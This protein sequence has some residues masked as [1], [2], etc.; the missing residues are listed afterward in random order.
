M[1][2]RK[3]VAFDP[4]IALGAMTF[5]GRTSAADG[6]RMIRRFL[7]EGY[8]WIDTAYVYTNGASERIVGQ[9]LKGRRSNAFLATKV[10]PGDMKRP[11]AGGLAPDKVRTRLN[12]SLKRLQT[13]YVDLLYLHAP[14]NATPLEATLAACQRLIEQGKVR[15]IGLSNYA[16]W[17][18]AEAAGICVQNGWP[19]PIIYQGMYNAITRQVESECIPACRHFGLDFIAYNPLAAGLL[20]GKHADVSSPPSKGRFA[21]EYYRKRYWKREYFDAIEVLDRAL[22]RSRIPMADASIRWLVHHSEADGVI[23][24]AG[25]VAHFEQNLVACS[26]GK[27]SPSLCRAFDKAWEI[28]RPV[29]DRYFRD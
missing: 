17:Q 8:S 18:V 4:I 29:C 24:G 13:E 5:G 15:E 19:A 2:R 10:Y 28:T 14:D 1:A 3:Q 25:S 26:K 6:K 11:T 21:G 7:D 22:G 12:T 16:A 27:L 23:L 20:T 9:A